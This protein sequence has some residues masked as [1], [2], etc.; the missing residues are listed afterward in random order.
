MAKDTI[1]GNYVDYAKQFQNN[2]QFRAVQSLLQQQSNGQ[3]PLLNQQRQLAN[4]NIEG[5]TIKALQGE[6]ERLA[7]SG[8]KMAGSAVNQDIYANE[9]N[10]KSQ[11]ELGFAEKQQQ[12]KNAAI[13]QLLG[14]QKD[15]LGYDIQSKQYNTSLNKMQ[16]DQYNFQEQMRLQRDQMNNENSFSFGDLLG[17]VGGAALGSFTGGLGTAAGAAI[18]KELFDGTTK[19][20]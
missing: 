1:F 3:D 5:S 7:Q 10:A 18:G 9:A 20:E 4:A 15:V 8:L 2:D 12:M 17:L 19:H 13:M 16:Q 6:K 11:V 14:L